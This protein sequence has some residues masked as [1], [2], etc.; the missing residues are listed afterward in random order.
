MR[1]LKMGMIGGGAGAFIGAI[2]RIA[3]LMD[4]EIELVCGAFSSDAE[5]SKSSGKA[6]FLDPARV[7]G[8]YEEMISKEKQLPEGERMD[9]V[10]IVTPNHMHFAPAKLALE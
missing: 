1:K 7:Y 5:K 8:S 4:G 2:H 3:A 9:I 10:S 6:L